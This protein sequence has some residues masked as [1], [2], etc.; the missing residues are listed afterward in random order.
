MSGYKMVGT[1][2]KIWWRTIIFLVI[3]DKRIFFVGECCSCLKSYTLIRYTLIGTT[4][5]PKFFLRNDLFQLIFPIISNWHI[6]TGILTMVADDLQNTCVKVSTLLWLQRLLWACCL[7]QKCMLLCNYYA[8]SA[9][10]TVIGYLLSCNEKKMKY[11][12]LQNCSKTDMGIFP[13][14]GLVVARK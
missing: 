8:V 13:A 2:K 6:A 10:K 3:L 7:C 11:H 4:H 14:F 9:W 5:R 12:I 1:G